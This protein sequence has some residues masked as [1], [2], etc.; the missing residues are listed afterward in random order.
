MT[1]FKNVS[2]GNVFS[3]AGLTWIKTDKDHA[4]TYDYDTGAM[5]TKKMVFAH[6]VIVEVL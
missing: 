6:T 2:V 1:A 3:W 4:T 5:G